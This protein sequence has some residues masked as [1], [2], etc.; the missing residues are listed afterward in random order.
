MCSCAAF[1]IRALAVAITLEFNSTRKLQHARTQAA[2]TL[3]RKQHARIPLSS[4]SLL[5]L[6]FSLVAGATL[7]TAAQDGLRR[8]QDPRRGHGRP[9]RLLLR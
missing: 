8:P 2:R 4:H 6:F 5:A 9:A 7:G 3:A 1:C